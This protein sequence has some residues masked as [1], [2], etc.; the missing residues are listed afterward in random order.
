MDL[1]T[2]LKW[3]AV[4]AL[5]KKK[6]N[7]MIRNH[8]LYHLPKFY[9]IWVNIDKVAKFHEMGGCGDFWNR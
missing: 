2:H 9:L 5:S 8:I 4:V 1:V 7:Q 3:V 6:N